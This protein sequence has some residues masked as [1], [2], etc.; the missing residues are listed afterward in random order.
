MDSLTVET[1]LFEYRE[2]KPHFINPNC[3]GE[4]FAAW[5][6]ERVAGFASEGFEISAPIQEDYGWGFWL[7]RA[8]DTFWVA[9]SFVDQVDGGGAQWVVSVA[10]DPGLSI[11]RRLFHQPDEAALARIRETVWG[12]L[13][14]TAG[15]RVVEQDEEER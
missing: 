11:L 7:S 4:D 12:T 9:I 13:R 15:I 5:L 3:F 14:T 10:Y 2:P 6:R 8:K 1:A